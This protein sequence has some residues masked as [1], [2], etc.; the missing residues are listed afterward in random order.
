MECVE[1]KNQP[2]LASLVNSVSLREHVKST[3]LVFLGF[4]VMISRVGLVVVG[5]F[6][7]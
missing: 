5:Y 7:F 2:Y 6:K 4:L 1:A 3:V